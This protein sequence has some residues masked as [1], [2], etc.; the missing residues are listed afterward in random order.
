MPRLFLYKS[1]APAT[2]DELFGALIKT[3]MR[4]TGMLTPMHTQT[5]LGPHV[6]WPLKYPI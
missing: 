2:V 3:R 4:G 6:I 5:Q 1:G